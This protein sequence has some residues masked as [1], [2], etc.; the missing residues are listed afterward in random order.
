MTTRRFPLHVGNGMLRIG[1][2]GGAVRPSSGYAFLRI[3]RQCRTL[4]AALAKGQMPRRGLLGRSRKHRTLDIVF[5]EA[6]RRKPSMAPT[7][8]HRLFSHASPAAVIRFLTERDTMSDDL[9]V[10]KALPIADFVR[11]ALYS[12]PLWGPSLWTNE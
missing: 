1:L 2:A 10:L 4:A 3:Q 7:Y 11:A 8:F 6:M 9:A 12:A 5:L